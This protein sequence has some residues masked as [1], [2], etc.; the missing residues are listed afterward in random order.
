MHMPV[1]KCICPSA[2]IKLPCMRSQLLIDIPVLK[3]LLTYAHLDGFTWVKRGVT[4]AKNGNFLGVA[5]A[6]PCMAIGLGS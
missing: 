5:S 1:G 4:F 2:G 3:T 6:K